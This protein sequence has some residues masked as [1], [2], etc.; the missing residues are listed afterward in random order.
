M[1]DGRPAG[2]GTSSLGVP[3][4][5]GCGRNAERGGH[6]PRVYPHMFSA[7]A[8]FG[9]GDASADY[10]LTALGTGAGFFAG[11]APNA[12]LAIFA[13]RS[14][15]LL[16]VRGATIG[17][18][19]LL[20]RGRGFAGA[21]G[22]SF[23]FGA[24]VGLALGTVGAV[25]DANAAEGRGAGLVVEVREVVRESARRAGAA[26]AA[27]DAAEGGRE[28]VGRA[29]LVPPKDW[30]EEEREGP[31]CEGWRTGVRET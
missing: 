1:E 11:V 5:W 24:G 4:L 3:I 9:D 19:K 6:H 21:A 10:A 15:A 26:P 2:G 12:A 18:C 14:S 16:F 29:E 27:V 17:A 13:A 20:G 30:R 7:V 31:V 25:F 23:S 22:S 28:N 8:R